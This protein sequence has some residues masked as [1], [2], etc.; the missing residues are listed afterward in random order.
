MR[1]IKRNKSVTKSC[2]SFELRT[3]DRLS[4]RTATQTNLYELR[5]ALLGNQSWSRN[6]VI[7]Q[8]CEIQWEAF[9]FGAEWIKTAAKSS[10]MHSYSAQKSMEGFSGLYSIGIASC[11]F[12]CVFHMWA[13]KLW[14]SKCNCKSCIKFAFSLSLTHSD[15]HISNEKAKSICN[16]ISHVLRAMNL[17]YLNSNIKLPHLPFQNELRL[18]RNLVRCIHIPHRNL[19]KDFPDY[20]Q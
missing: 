4:A 11:I 10:E 15:C 16:C 7:A 3:T 2:Y 1:N 18:L 14:Q 19:W 5:T 17:S 9:E 8:C 13:H 6:S 12:N 20:I